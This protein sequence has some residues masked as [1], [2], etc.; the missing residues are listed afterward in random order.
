M[1]FFPR[2]FLSG[3]WRSNWPQRY[4]RAAG[5]ISIYL[6]KK[7]WSYKN[8]KIFLL[9]IP[10]SEIILWYN[11]HGILKPLEF[12]ASKIVLSSNISKDL[13]EHSRHLNY[14]YSKFSLKDHSKCSSIK[15]EITHLPFMVSNNFT[16]WQKCVETLYSLF[17]P[18]FWLEAE[19]LSP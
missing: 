4:K 14:S 17:L 3:S 11:I 5:K 2:P 19:R 13:E 8:N 18:V 6:K 10:S 16:I 9:R 12:K 1:S 15:T 7:V